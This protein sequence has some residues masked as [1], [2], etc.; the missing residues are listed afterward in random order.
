MAD[1]A[2]LLARMVEVSKPEPPKGEKATSPEDVDFPQEDAMVF[3]K[4]FEN[5]DLSAVQR[6]DALKELVRLLK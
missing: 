3:M 1:K 2:G 4:D 6:L 5:T